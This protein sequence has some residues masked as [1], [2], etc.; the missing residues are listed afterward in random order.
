MK[1][2]NET[3]VGALT[4]VAITVLI[5][6]F[7]YLKGKSISTSSNTIYA[8]FPS[9][10][11]IQVSTIVTI[12]G[13]Q[14][15]KVKDIIEKDKNLTGII[16]SIKLT[17]DINIPDNS[18]ATG[19]SDLLGNSS[20][21]ITKGAS[22]SYLKDGD[23]IQTVKA[24]GLVDRLQSTLDPT[25]D[26]VN[27]TLVALEALIQKIGGIFDP[28]AKNNLQSL[29]ANLSMSSKSLEQLLNTQ[30]GML[31]KSLN[32]VEA[33]TGNLAKNN[34][35][36]TATL[37]NLQKTSDN[38]ANAKIPEAI[39]TL[40]QAMNGLQTTIA[41]MNSNDGSLGLLLNDR[42]LYNQLNQTVRSLNILLDDL[43]VHPKRYVNISVFGKKDKSGPL[44]NPITDSTSIQRK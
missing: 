5:L 3:K 42:Q 30:T 38:L 33:F 34:E 41:K 11:G 17:K 27:K 31:S 9:V 32:N 22:T 25:L 29:I 4:A 36:I 21:K 8:V 43:R 12:N 2:S 35:K 18:I 10:E 24:P 1:I 23:T 37:D 19:N 39:A 16:V 7:N 13:L 40:Q 28:T 15:G 44:M 6:G 14:I 26:N 20:I